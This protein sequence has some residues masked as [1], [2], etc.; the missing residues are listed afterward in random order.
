[1]RYLFKLIA[2]LISTCSNRKGHMGRVDLTR[3]TQDLEEFRGLDNEAIKSIPY[4]TL[5][6]KGD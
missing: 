3:V 6:L 5:L 1:M 4:K 2:R